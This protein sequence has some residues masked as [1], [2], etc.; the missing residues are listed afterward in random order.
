MLDKVYVLEFVVK[1]YMKY[2]IT[3]SKQE[4]SK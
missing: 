3:E 4:I 2:N 1:Y